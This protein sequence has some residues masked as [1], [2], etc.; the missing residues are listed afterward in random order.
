MKELHD[1]LYDKTAHNE[2]DPDG[3][4]K[5]V[6]HFG[7]LCNKEECNFKHYCNFN[8]RQVLIKAWKKE[9]RSHEGAKLVEAIKGKITTAELEQLMKL[10]NIRKEKV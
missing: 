3:V 7:L 4:R 6:C 1:K 10:L 5:V 9:H 8:G 2:T